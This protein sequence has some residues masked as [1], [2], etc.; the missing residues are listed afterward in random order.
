MAKK[1]NKKPGSNTIAK[2][3]SAR[4]EFAITDEYEAGISLQGW[5][6]KAIRDGKVNMTESY[7]YLRNGEVFISG[8]TITPLQAASTHVVA[9]PTRIRKLLLNRREIDKLTGAVNRDGETIVALNM[10]WKASFV[11]VKIGTARG[12]KLHDK[13]AD[14]KARDWQRDKAR[15]MKGSLR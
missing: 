4:F 12:K 1:P 2:N 5:E 15:I 13:R 8:L 11:K 14:T 3:K 9:D 6:V 10:Y 7:V